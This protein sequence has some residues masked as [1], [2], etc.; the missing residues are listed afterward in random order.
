[1]SIFFLKYTPKCQQKKHPSDP[2]MNAVRRHNP[3]HTWSPRPPSATPSSHS[4]RGTV[5]SPSPSSGAL[6][7]TSGATTCMPSGGGYDTGPTSTVVCYDPAT[8]AWSV[9]DNGT[10]FLWCRCLRG[11]YLRRRG[12][13]P[14]QGRH[15]MLIF[16]VLRPCGRSL[17]PWQRHD[18]LTR[19]LS[20]GV[21]FTLLGA[22]T[23]T[24]MTHA[25]C[26]LWSA[27]T[28][29]LTCGRSSRR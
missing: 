12:L 21:F 11:A 25:A 8:G 26:P 16:R 15:T 13:S 1:M 5:S 19:S 22:V 2:A 27:T 24:T 14:A 28:P 20:S 3:H 23:T 9:V 7:A 17:R 29:P 10:K 6:R 4:G 18:V